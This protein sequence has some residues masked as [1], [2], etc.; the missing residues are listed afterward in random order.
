[1]KK[2]LSLAMLVCLVCSNAWASRRTAHTSLNVFY[3]LEDGK[4]QVDYVVKIPVKKIK[5]LK[6]ETLDLGHSYGYK[7][8][9]S[10]DSEGHITA[11]LDD[12][13]VFSIGQLDLSS[14]ESG[15]YNTTREEVKIRLV[16][17]RSSLQWNGFF[18][19]GIT[20]CAKP[21]SRKRYF[22]MEMTN[23]EGEVICLNYGYNKSP[24]H[25]LGK[26]KK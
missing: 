16:R 20:G 22:Q 10:I 21:V 15:E 4:P 19:C 6:R 25:L 24:R 5:W 11:E 9:F 3:F 8:I 18:S 26:C 12:G 13:K 17:R 1:M 23:K 2:L 14:A 7:N